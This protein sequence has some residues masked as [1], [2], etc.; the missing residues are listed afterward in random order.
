MDLDEPGVE[1]AGDRCVECG[2]ALTSRELEAVMESGGP[3]L[4]AIH[5]AEDEPGLA[6]PRTAPSP[7][8]APP[9][10]P[11]G[12]DGTALGQQDDLAD[13]PACGEPVVGLDRAL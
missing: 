2:A 1:P 7:R 9:A 8:T 11:G 3:A 6:G 10:A 12:G 4:C 5:A 13:L